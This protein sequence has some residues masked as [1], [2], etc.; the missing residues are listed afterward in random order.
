MQV[1]VG[2]SFPALLVCSIPSLP[3]LHSRQQL[4]IAYHI[5]FNKRR[6]T[7]HITTI[8][9]PTHIIDFALRLDLIL[10]AVQ[11]LVTPHCF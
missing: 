2:N 10:V 9:Y 6:H 8:Y 4:Y 5:F 3:S 7:S 11:S 1:F